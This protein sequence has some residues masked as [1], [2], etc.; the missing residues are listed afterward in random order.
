MII[1]QAIKD[2]LNIRNILDGGS[3]K[4]CPAALANS[5]ISNLNKRESFTEETKSKWDSCMDKKWCKIVAIVCIVIGCLIV[6]WIISIIMNVIFC[7]GKCIRSF[8]WCCSC[9]SCCCH[10]HPPPPPPPPPAKPPIDSRGQAYNNPNMYYHP[11]GGPNTQQYYY[12]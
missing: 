1:P 7:G 12:S 10:R 2:N 11:Q 9:N 8:C 5:L 6:L 4:L 3:N